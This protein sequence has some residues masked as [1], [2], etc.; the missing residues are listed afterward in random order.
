[1][2]RPDLS[3]AIARSSRFAK[4]PLKVNKSICNI[5]GIF[6]IARMRFFTLLLVHAILGM[7]LSAFAANTRFA[8]G[9]LGMAED[10]REGALVDLIAADLSTAPGL[11]LV[12]RRELNAALKEAGLSLSGVVRAKEAVHAG[13]LLR[14]DQFLLGSSIRLNGTNILVIR[15]VDAKTGIIRAIDI[16]RDSVSLETLAGEI[17]KFV[18]ER[19]N[20]ILQEHRDYLTIGIVQNLGVNNRFL[21]FPAHLRGY[22]AANLSGKVPC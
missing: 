1:M 19:H 8:I 9:T 11:D 20:G 17:A 15:L 5:S 3:N 13:A 4:L 2:P 12:E 7:S 10:T 22:V 18:R 21:R 14:V 16:F 6:V